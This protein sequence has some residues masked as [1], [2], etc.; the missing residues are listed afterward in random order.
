MEVMMSWKE[1]IADIIGSLAWPAAVLTVAYL[2]RAE[3][4]RLIDRLRS[5]TRGTWR[6]S[7]L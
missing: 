7:S 6:L 3:F 4:A 2:F 1:F 5:V